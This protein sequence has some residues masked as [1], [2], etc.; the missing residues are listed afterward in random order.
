MEIYGELIEYTDIFLAIL[1]AIE[2]IIDFDPNTLNHKSKGKWVTVYIELPERYDVCDTD[3][4]SIYLNNFISAALSPSEID[5]I[6]K[7]GVEDL[8]VKFEREDVLYLLNQ[9]E[10]VEVIIS[11]NLYDG[12]HFEG[13][14]SI[15]VI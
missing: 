1:A 3:V 5:D 9:G 15:K 13:R 8:M 6:D 7:D 11:G 2:A 12:T 4:G 14:D 10:N